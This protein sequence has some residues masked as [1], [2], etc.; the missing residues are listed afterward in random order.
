MAGEN[1]LSDKALRGLYGK[2]QSGQRMIADGRGLSVRVSKSGCL[3][4]VFLFRHGDRHSAPIWMSLGR[5]PDMTLK[6]AREKRDQCR[7]WLS[8][9]LDPR[10]E[11]KLHREN[12][13]QPVTVKE[14]IDYWFE[15]YAK[16]KRKESVRIYRR[17][18]K[19]IFPYIGDYPAERCTL[20]EWL[21][22]F[23]RIKKVAPVQS[24]SM[25]I[26]LKQIFKFC[27]V[28]QYV[29]CNVL[30]DLSPTDVGKYQEKR[31][32][33]LCDDYLADLWGVYFHGDG[34]SR[35]M[36]Y[37]KRMAIL[38]LVFGCRHGEVRISSWSEWDFNNWTWTVPKSHSKNGM[39]IVRPV[40]HRLRQWITDLHE[41]T[42][43][44][45]YIL[46]KFCSCSTVSAQ[47]CTNWLSLKHTQR[48]S[49]HDLRRTISTRL[50][51]MGVDFIVVEQ[52]LGHAIKGV[53]GIYNRSQYLEQKLHALDKWCDFLDGL[54][55]VK[56]RSNIG[57]L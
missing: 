33:I 26:E 4:F 44:D 29:N 34:K 41:E 14:S 1:K 56:F 49:L 10:I 40:P 2:P 46:G 16:E 17:Y 12:L 48:W 53:A 6:Q 37:K 47:G 21:E 38:C 36:N 32:R 7:S 23:D 11:N 28:R 43:R 31:E 25:L 8:L 24:A 39:E 55:E 52:L 57:S 20:T 3:T 9:G 5:Y 54:Y 42:K 35:V 22:C 27:R 50:N 51:D 45:K 13:F 15:N 19:Y 18:E 30:N